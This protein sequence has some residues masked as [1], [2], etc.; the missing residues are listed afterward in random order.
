M[1]CILALM[2]AS[3]GYGQNV[4]LYQQFSGR[5][6]Y[7]FVGNTLNAVE[8][9]S[10]VTCSTLP[11]SAASLQLM[12]GSTIDKAFLYWAGSGTGD[13]SV[14]LNGNPITAQ[15][16]FAISYGTRPF[17][18]AFADVTALVTAQGNGNYVF[19]DLDIS[20][21]IS[22]YCI[23]GGNFAGWAIVVVYRNPAL[24]I[25]QINLYDGMQGVPFQLDIH[26]TNLFI[27]DTSNATIGFIA[28]EG[29]KSLAFS[30]TL[31]VNTTVM[32]NDLN[33]PD[34]AFNGT[35]SV[36]GVG[37]DTL[38]NMD[39]D[40]YD[41][42]SALNVGDT[43]A[44]I[45][46]TSGEIING[47]INGDFVMI[48]AV[49]TKLSS[50]L[51][52]ISVSI[53]DVEKSCNSR[54]LTVHYALHNFDSNE[55]L[56]AGVPVSVY[57]G[58]QYIT[59]FPLPIDLAVG[60]T[61]NGI[62]TFD[63]PAG[64]PDTFDIIFKADSD[65]NGN[66]T[67]I[68]TLETNNSTTVSGT[69]IYTPVIQP[70]LEI[71]ACNKGLGKGVFDLTP[72]ETSVKTNPADTVRFFA[73]EENAINGMPTI[74][75]PESYAATAPAQ[76]YVRVDNADGCFTIAAIPLKTRNCPPVVYNYVQ[77][78]T[79]HHELVIDGIKD[80]FPNYKLTVFNRWGTVVYE[81]NRDTAA[82]NGTSNEGTRFLGNHLPGGT[83]FYILDLKDPEYASPVTGFLY[84]N[85]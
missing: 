17:F 24:P 54:T 31:T 65:A 49:V 22:N 16:T 36:M 84:L 80:I 55:V 56:A 46:L 70:P 35:N 58:T 69:L 42:S 61:Y 26:L 4:S 3:A 57:A 13:F 9:E 63:L 76:V 15:R 83:Y 8:N 40:I 48:N 44:D 60:E 34:N 41:V 52:D 74:T 18:S 82:F 12:A 38:Y 59:T 67:V 64:I 50:Q 43:E 11:S 10:T 45:K 79:A 72:F 32:Q 75:N 78:D 19:S 81:G 30:E 25:K 2:A 53:N 39:L 37:S 68:E 47:A 6:D 62:I 7:T 51:P 29:D 5:C 23:T 14:K 33:P 66:G 77:P 21:I 20:T 85:Q 73:S 27:S 71:V 1:F 28:W